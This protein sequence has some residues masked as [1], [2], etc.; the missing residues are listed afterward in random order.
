[1]THPSCFFQDVTLVLVALLVMAFL[2]SVLV[3]SPCPGSRTR[4]ARLAHWPGG[5]PAGTTLCVVCHSPASPWLPGLI[6]R[7]SLQ[8][9]PTPTTP[10]RR[11]DPDKPSTRQTSSRRYAA[12]DDTVQYRGSISGP[13]QGAKLTDS[14]SGRLGR[15]N[16]QVSS[17]RARALSKFPRRWPTW[18]Q[19]ASFEAQ[20]PPH[21]LSRFFCRAQRFSARPSIRSTLRHSRS[22]IA[23]PS[24]LGFA[25]II[26]SLCSRQSLSFN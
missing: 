12:L 3:I 22:C 15:P 8:A 21:P 6:N 20:Y 14:Q 23:S 11:L 4:V 9:A 24:P 10:A 18:S 2:V 19:A 17:L 25:C 7:H 26:P 13:P 5:H 16:L 1:M